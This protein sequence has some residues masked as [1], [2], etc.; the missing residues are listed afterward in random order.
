MSETMLFAFDAWRGYL[1]SDAELV[2]IREKVEAMPLAALESLWRA[3]VEPT[4]RAVL[5]YCE[6]PGP[7]LCME[8]QNPVCKGS[9]F[10]AVHSRLHRD[11]SI[12][13]AR[14]RDAR[15]RADFCHRAVQKNAH[16]LMQLCKS[17]A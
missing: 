16:V 9:P 1:E 10:C 14:I 6:S 7:V 17:G 8:C 4:V 11:E 2:S 13:K 12:R 15:R 5:Q 3:G